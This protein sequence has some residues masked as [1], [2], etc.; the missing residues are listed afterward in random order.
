M[1]ARGASARLPRLHPA[2]W[3]ST[4]FGV[5]CLPWAPGTW[6]SLATVLIAY[7]LG[8]YLS[9]AIM[10]SAALTIFLVGWW[11]SAVYVARTGREDAS[12]IVIDEV[13]GQ[14]L[15]L[16]FVPAYGPWYVVGFVAFRVFDVLKPFPANWCDR[17]VKGG[18]GVMADDMIAGTYA[19][20]LTTL[21]YYLWIFI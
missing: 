12:E 19:A 16:A 4:F 18:L 14:L 11:A 1:T 21:G 6:G 9:P 10:V 8:R 15:A 5:G 20:I 17:S 7:G 3:I 13:A 2:W